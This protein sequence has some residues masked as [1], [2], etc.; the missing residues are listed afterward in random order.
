MKRLQRFV[1]SLAFAGLYFLAAR[2]VRSYDLTA[3]SQ[4]VQV[5]LLVVAGISTGLAV[6]MLFV[7]APLSL[8]IPEPGQPSSSRHGIDDR[9]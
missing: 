2:G 7:V 6:L 8:V 4:A 3:Q 9:I 5:I 1:Q